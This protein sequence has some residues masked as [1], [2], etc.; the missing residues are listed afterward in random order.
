M[1]KEKTEMVR[2]T[3]LNA[4]VEKLAVIKSGE[5]L[6]KEMQLEIRIY[7]KPHHQLRPKKSLVA[8]TVK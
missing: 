7:C 2:R 5:R 8:V 6:R 4:S 3:K 1:A